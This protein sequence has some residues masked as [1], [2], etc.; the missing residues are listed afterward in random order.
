M[1]ALFK[2]NILFF[3]KKTP[4][5]CN[6]TNPNFVGI[7]TISSYKGKQVIVTTETLDA[8]KSFMKSFSF[9]YDLAIGLFK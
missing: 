8:F 6:W 7:E 4:S 9:N 5:D 1:L 3:F 2:K